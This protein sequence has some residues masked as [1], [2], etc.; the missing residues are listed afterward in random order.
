MTGSSEPESNLH[1]R[2]VY[3]S[4]MGYVQKGMLYVKT[5][6]IV[7]MH[8]ALMPG[9]LAAKHERKGTKRRPKS[10]CDSGTTTFLG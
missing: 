9:R 7:Q 10:E 6:T 1:K 4:Y 8:M 2:G 5:L 3:R